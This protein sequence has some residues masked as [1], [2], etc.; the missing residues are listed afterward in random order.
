M[1]R[2][3]ARCHRCPFM[4]RPLLNTIERSSTASIAHQLLVCSQC[5]RNVRVAQRLVS[6]Q[7]L[8]EAHCMLAETHWP[9]G[10]RLWPMCK[11]LGRDTS[12]IRKQSRVCW[13]PCLVCTLN[14]TTAPLVTRNQTMSTRWPFRRADAYIASMIR[15]SCRPSSPGTI[16]GSPSSSALASLSICIACK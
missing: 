5:R 15:I 8:I 13:P 6:M 10:R 7:S 14:T 12:L 4:P 2:L 11:G 16:N 3:V 9:P 1:S